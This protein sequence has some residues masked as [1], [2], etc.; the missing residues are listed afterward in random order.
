MRKKDHGKKREQTTLHIYIFRHGQTYFNRDH[1]FTGWKDSKLTPLGIKQAKKIGHK[2]A[3]KKF[4]LAFCTTLSRSGDTL[5]HVLG[6]QKNRRKIRIVFDDRMRERRYGKLEGTHHSTFVER[7][8]EDSYKT[9][10]HWH[11][12]D[13]LSGKDRKEFVKKVGEAELQ[14]IRRSYD[15]APPGGESIRMVEKRV[16]PF[17][18]DLLKMMKKQKVNV[19][20][21]AHGNS[22]R[23]F[24]RYFEHLS[25]EEMMKLEN[26]WNDYFEYTIK[27]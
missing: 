16:L 1:I 18:R 17:I 23:P 27:V 15:V 19:A 2:L 4:D 11:K 21:S 8:G 22:M 3:H 9:L 24:R 12:I 14:V 20:I 10:Q 7:E 26:P 25:I 6:C 5:K 13:H